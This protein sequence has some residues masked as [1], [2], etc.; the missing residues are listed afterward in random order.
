VTE[1]GPRRFSIAENSHVALVIYD[2]NGKLV[3]TLVDEPRTANEHRVIWDGKN[4]AGMDV[5][6][7]IYFY[8]VTAGRFHSTQKMVL[9]R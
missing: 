6:S 4:D 1:T 3:R 2:V 9:L 5:A 7:G 8:C